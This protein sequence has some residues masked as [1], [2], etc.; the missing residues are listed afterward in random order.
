MA[1]NRCKLFRLEHVDWEY[2]AT[3]KSMLWCGYVYDNL[4]G[5][6]YAGIH[7]RQT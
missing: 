5:I 1:K 2:V 3:V 7:S 6:F 4:N